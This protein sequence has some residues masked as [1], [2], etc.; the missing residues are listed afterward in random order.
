MLLIY[1]WHAEYDTF[2]KKN[3]I[4]GIKVDV[5]IIYFM[6]LHICGKHIALPFHKKNFTHVRCGRENFF[7]GRELAEIFSFLF[8]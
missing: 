4:D 7:N 3:T 5:K 6:V 1:A 2:N 8:F